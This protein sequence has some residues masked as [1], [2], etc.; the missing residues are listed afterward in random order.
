MWVHDVLLYHFE[1]ITRSNEVRP[2]EKRFITERWG[3]Y[4]EVEERYST[5]VR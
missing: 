4:L 1:S 5:N 3:D 2:W